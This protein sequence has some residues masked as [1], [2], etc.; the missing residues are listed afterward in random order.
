MKI[1]KKI[2]KN[3]DELFYLKNKSAILLE[4]VKELYFN[5]KSYNEVQQMY[6]SDEY[7]NIQKTIKEHVDTLLE[8]IDSNEILITLDYHNILS[9]LYENQYKSRLLLNTID[10]KNSKYKIFQDSLEYINKQIAEKT[11]LIELYYIKYL[12]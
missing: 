7:N 12:T 4:K 8:K 11:C 3:I 1:D 5:I 2:I 6:Y 10:S 9:I